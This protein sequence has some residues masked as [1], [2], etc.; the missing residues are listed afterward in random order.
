[1]VGSIV[2]VNSLPS[3]S[4]AL[5]TNVRASFGA[6]DGLISNESSAT[7]PYEF[8]L[9]SSLVIESCCLHL[10]VTVADVLSLE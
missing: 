3:L 7:K 6:D 10:A 9:Y 2:I 5:T 4:V 1:L 8:Q